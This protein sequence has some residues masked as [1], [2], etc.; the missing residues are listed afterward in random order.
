MLGRLV[1]HVRSEYPGID[2]VVET[3]SLDR[4]DSIAVARTHPLAQR[5]RVTLRELEAHTWVRHAP[6]AAD[7]PTRILQ[8]VLT[9]RGFMPQSSRHAA[10]DDALRMLVRAGTGWCALP[11]S[12]KPA[13]SGGMV[14]IPVEDL[15]VPF[16][17]VHIHRRGDNRPVVKSV[18]GALRRAVRKEGYAPAAREPDSGVKEIPA[19]ERT[20]AS[21]IELRHLRYFVAAIEHET[22]G[23][24]AEQLGIT[25]PALSRQLR[26]L[27]EEIGGTLLHCTAP[28]A[29]RHGRP[30]RR[31]HRADTADLGRHHADGGASLSGVSGHRRHRR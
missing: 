12:L 16:R 24:A 22:I 13:M 26:D 15:A 11:R 31:R 21:R 7:E 20:S 10:N 25:Q 18:L 17:Y 30:L 29:A 1:E 14:A 19:V 8:S 27:E 4:I 2:I 9:S 3:H 28:R 6:T 23:R 5:E